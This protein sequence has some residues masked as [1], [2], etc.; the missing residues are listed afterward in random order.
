MAEKTKHIP[1]ARPFR[2]EYEDAKE[3]IFLAVSTAAKKHNIPY[4]LLDGIITEVLYQ[5]K[6]GARDE[7]TNAEIVYHRQL[8]EYKNQIK[9][10]E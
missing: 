5:V 8:T 4:F 9:K 6:D 10:E 3:E 2:L 1:P 7:K